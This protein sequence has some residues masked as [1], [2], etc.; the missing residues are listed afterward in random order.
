MVSSNLKVLLLLS[1][2]MNSNGEAVS[3]GKIFG[4]VFT[5]ICPLGSGVFKGTG[6]HTDTLP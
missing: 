4:P 5:Q 6:K 1:K 2:E 3:S